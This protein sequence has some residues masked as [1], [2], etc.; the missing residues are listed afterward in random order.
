MF[1]R[2]YALLK[3][4]YQVLR[5]QPRLLVYPFA[6][7][8]A[9]IATMLLIVAP[10]AL[11]LSYLLH[12]LGFVTEANAEQFFSSWPAY[13]LM[14]VLMLVV[15]L[16]MNLF[17]VAFYEAADAALQGETIGFWTTMKRAW[18]RKKRI[19]QWTVF[20]AVVGLGLA[21]I[22]DKLGIFGKIISFIGSLAWGLATLFALP[23]LIRH[24]MG[25]IELVRHSAGLF[26][27]TWGE[28]VVIGASIG[29]FIM[30]AM[31]FTIAL[32]AA[33]MIPLLA[34]GAIT[35]SVAVGIGILCFLLMVM[36]VAY[37]GTLQI[38]FNLA[39]YRYAENND[40][41]G[42]FS[43]ELIESAFV[44]KKRMKLPFTR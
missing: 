34:Q 39:L 3:A 14:A 20:S 35:T 37:L 4:S 44:P 13:A 8:I 11:G 23:I 29:I 15:Q 19:L 38:I 31:F 25:P 33:L 41:V 36:S 32:P 6:S 22:H 30:I 40:Y 24:D 16:V 9:F 43:K 7:L 12:R 42:P 21:I 26:K 10:A 5:M 18:L 1:R 17:N 28:N 2:S 27:K